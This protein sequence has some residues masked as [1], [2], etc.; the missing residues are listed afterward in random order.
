MRP[1]TIYP[2][3]LMSKFYIYSMQLVFII[4][5]SNHSYSSQPA[6]YTYKSQRFFYILYNN[7]SICF[8]I[9]NKKYQK[10]RLQITSPELWCIIQIF[11]AKVREHIKSW[12]WKRENQLL[13]HLIKERH[14]FDDLD[15]VTV[16]HI[17][18]K[19]QCLWN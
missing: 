9:I 2:I 12:D 14:N 1:T 17:R 8:V 10:R 18:L 4:T 16:F 5:Y 19:I 13:M 3:L 11:E 15:N 7:N 6:F